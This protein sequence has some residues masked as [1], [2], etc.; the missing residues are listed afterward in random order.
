[1]DQPKRTSV[2][3]L[4]GA[5]L[6][7]AAAGLFASQAVVPAAVAAE[8]KVQCSGVNACKGKSDCATAK[9]GC[10]GQNE[11]KGQG[12]VKMTEKECKAKGGVVE[13]T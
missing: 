8:A 12:W 5:A 10:H 6:A 3:R 7:V 1:M 11:C 4:S 13:K 9:N 2:K